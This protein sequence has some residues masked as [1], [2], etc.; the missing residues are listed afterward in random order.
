MSISLRLQ[1]NITFQGC[2][3]TVIP[4]PNITAPSIYFFYPDTLRKNP[5]YSDG[6]FVSLYGSI[7]P[8]KVLRPR[9]FLA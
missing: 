9:P 1:N 8:K 7:C 6:G 3:H 5:R 2:G 4:P